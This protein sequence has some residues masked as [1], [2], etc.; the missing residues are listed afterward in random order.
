M[1]FQNIPLRELS[2]NAANIRTDLGD[3]TELIDS[4]AAV[5]ILQPLVVVPAFGAD[6]P[7]TVIAG[8]RRLAAAQA[9]GLYSV[10]CIVR[11]DLD[12]T[13]QL[14]AQIIENTTRKDL[15]PIEEAT[16]FTQL[17]LL[18]LS[19]GDIAKRTG[20]KRATIEAR[21]RLMD[22]PES[23][24]SKV[25]AH[26][27]SLTEAETMLEF[28][29]NP[30][31][32]AR[33]TDVAGS[34]NFRWTVESIRGGRIRR[35]REAQEAAAKA[36][37]EMS[38]EVGTPQPTPVTRCAMCWKAEAIDG[39]EYCE[40]CAEKRAAAKAKDDE[41]IAAHNVRIAWLREQFKTVNTEVLVE[42]LMLATLA[43][44]IDGDADRVADA[45]N[46]M[47]YETDA[48]TVPS[49]KFMGG[50][51]AAAVVAVVTLQLL[52]DDKWTDPARYLGL[53]SEFAGYEMS[54]AERAMFDAWDADR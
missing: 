13:A 49:V 14:V 54:D 47:G 44:L 30:D 34:P 15:N 4:I 40:K 38:G 3:L 36:L 28:A 26:Q 19:A 11:G 8:N 16:A 2:S 10:P 41:R 18:G 6:I 48:D 27:V 22:L 23:T 42:R 29:D 17:E 52:A 33:L 9:V 21:T 35:E 5:G 46:V 32:V 1:T 24:R 51:D 37:R 20:R 31:D 25:A 45:L 53:L 39:T 7:W 50:T 12:S 43:D